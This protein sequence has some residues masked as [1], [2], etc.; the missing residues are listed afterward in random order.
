MAFFNDLVCLADHD[1]ILASVQQAET[2]YE[3]SIYTGSGRCFAKRANPDIAVGF[4]AR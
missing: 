2:R 1:E 3:I 4:E